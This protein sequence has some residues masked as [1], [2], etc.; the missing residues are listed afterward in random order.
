MN[1]IYEID[2][3]LIKQVATYYLLAGLVFLFAVLHFGFK[4]PDEK[5]DIASNL[6]VVVMTVIAF[7]PYN[8]ICLVFSWPVWTMPVG[9]LFRKHR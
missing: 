4:N 6:G 5:T 8:L 1:I 7:W 2:I 9:E 3:D